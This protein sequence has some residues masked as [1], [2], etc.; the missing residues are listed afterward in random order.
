MPITVSIGSR[1]VIGSFLI[2]LSLTGVPNLQPS[3]K[4]RQ[5]ESEAAVQEALNELLRKR[6]GMT[7]IIIAHR[8]QTVRSVDTIFVMKNGAVIEEGAHDQLL[9][10]TNGQYRLMLERVDSYG[11]LPVS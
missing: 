5:Q 9:Q 7:T 2:S 11:L 1:Y 6:L 4:L 3:C 10:K 8:L